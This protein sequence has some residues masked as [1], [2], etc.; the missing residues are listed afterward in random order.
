MKLQRVDGGSANERTTGYPS[1]QTYRSD[2]R[3]FLETVVAG[4]TALVA[5]ATV[6][7]GCRQTRTAGEPPPP[8]TGPDVVGPPGVPP[9]PQSPSTTTWMGVAEPLPPP[10]KRLL[11]KIRQPIPPVRREAELEGDIAYPEPPGE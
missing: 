1:Y 8:T 5:G 7:A 9:L 3:R 4:V 11:G 10:T 2:R 6:L